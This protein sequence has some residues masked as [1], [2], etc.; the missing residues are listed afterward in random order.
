MSNPNQNFAGARRIPTDEDKAGNLAQRLHQIA[1]IAPVFPIA[2]IYIPPQAESETSE[3]FHARRLQQIA[4]TQACFAVNY[5]II[6]D[7]NIIGAV[8]QTFVKK[9]IATA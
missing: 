9:P 7:N 8:S 6:L 3:N 2:E 5:A 1:S 4:Q